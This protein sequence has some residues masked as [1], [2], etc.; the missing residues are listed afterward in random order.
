MKCVNKNQ[1]YISLLKPRATNFNKLDRTMANFKIS[2]MCGGKY[3][4]CNK[5]HHE[6][7]KKH[8]RYFTDRE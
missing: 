1:K 7:S 8:Q 2:C 6:K 4:Y 5:T 3:T